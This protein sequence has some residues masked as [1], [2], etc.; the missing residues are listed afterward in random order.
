MHIPRVESRS[1]DTDQDVCWAGEG[2]EGKSEKI[3]EGRCGVRRECEGAH[4]SGVSGHFGDWKYIKVWR[5]KNE[6]CNRQR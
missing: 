6:G 1:D 3:V 5:F 4:C 2:G